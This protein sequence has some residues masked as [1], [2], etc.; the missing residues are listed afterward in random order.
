MIA[1]IRRRIGATP[2]M[3]AVLIM[4]LGMFLFTANDAVGKW[5]TGSYSVGQLMFVRGVVALAILLPLI[6]QTGLGRLLAVEQPW[7]LALR[8]LLTVVD[9]FAFY[10]A[11]SLLPLADV[12]TFWLAA[13]IYVAA[14]SPLL[15]GE[16]VGWRRWTAIAVGFAGVIVA[17]EPSRQMLS[18]AALASLGGSLAFGF[19]MLTARTLRSTAG[20]TMIFWQSMGGL[21]AGAMTVP[22]SWTT[23]PPSQWPAFILF[24]VLAMLAHVS[25]NLAFKLADASAIAPL[26]YT[27]LLWAILFGWVVFGD[28]PSS[29]KFIGAALIVASGLFIFLRERQLKKTAQANR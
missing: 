4:L 14:F 19:A 5:L 25:V 2:V 24:G 10:Y 16:H 28:F 27:Q 9:G 15:L 13:P 6:R 1:A 29:A 7:T 12:M 11:V 23:P 8:V 21:I 26:Q 17:L 3:S 18:Y 20:I 22:F